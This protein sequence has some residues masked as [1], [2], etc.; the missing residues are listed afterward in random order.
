M[1]VTCPT[2]CDDGNVKESEKHYLLSNS[3]QNLVHL[4]YWTPVSCVDL[5]IS[6]KHT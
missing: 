5:F 6:S 3:D 4:P 1:K 2:E